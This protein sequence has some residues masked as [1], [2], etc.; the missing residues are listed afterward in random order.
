MGED[1]NYR[2]ILVSILFLSWIAIGHASSSVSVA[3]YPN[4]HAYVIRTYNLDAKGA[5]SISIDDISNP[6]PSSISLFS[7]G[8]DV[9]TLSYLETKKTRQV[10]KSFDDLL[11]ESIGKRIKVWTSDDMVAE[12]EL[13]WYD[14]MHLG[15]GSNSS[16]GIVFKSGIIRMSLP[17]SSAYK[18]EDYFERTLSLF[19]MAKYGG[20]KVS[21]GYPK[22]DLAWTITYDLI[23]NDDGSSA[24]FV[25][26]ATISNNGDESYDNADIMLTLINPN[27]AD[28][29]YPIRSFA[30]DYK[31]GVSNAALESGPITFQPELVGGIWS[32]EPDSKMDIPAGGSK[33]LM[34]FSD[35]VP[36]FKKFVWDTYIGENVHTT[37]NLTNVRSEILPSG[38]VRVIS[39]GRFIGQDT[40]SMLPSGDSVE[41]FVSDAPQF[42]VSKQVLSDETG[43][44]FNDRTQHTVT[45][46]LSISNFDSESQVVEVRDYIPQYADFKLESASINPKQI[47]GNKIV[48]EVSVDGDGGVAYIDYVYSYSSRY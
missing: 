30:Y 36:L 14:G 35:D 43:G 33:L 28:A 23:P 48:W 15:I 2:A 25:Q 45:V 7:N 32:Y 40:I 18:D 3:L 5:F 11:N 41:L 12:G 29:Y 37:Y 16:M 17:E 10:M 21:L 44:I 38:A 24:K 1:M 47:D 26:Y 34:L 20:A 9:Y 22:D 31:Y 13:I 6:N 42:K 39:N 8:A 4:S 27:F 46:R 19:G